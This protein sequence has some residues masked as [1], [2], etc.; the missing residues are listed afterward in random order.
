MR[1]R[2]PGFRLRLWWQPR[3]PPKTPFDP[4]TPEEQ[5]AEALLLRHLSPAQ[6]KTYL[7]D[8]WFEVRG[9]DGSLWTIDSDGGS[10]NVRCI[11]GSGTWVYCSFLPD[12]PRADTLLVQKLCIEATGGRGLPRSEGGSVTDEHLFHTTPQRRRRAIAPDPALL[13]QAALQYRAVSRLKYAE[14]LLRQ[15]IRIEDRRLPADSPRRPHRRTEL[16]LVLL[17]RGRFTAARRIAA[18]AWRLA[19]GRDDLI[20]A[21][22]LVVRIAAGW[23]GR[24]RD[25]GLQLGQLKTLAAGG[26]PRCPA[27]IPATWHVADVIETL[28]RKLPGAQAELVVQLVKVIE[29]RARPTALDIF[30]AWTTAAPVPLDAP[31]PPP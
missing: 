24:K 12:V 18:E 25:V 2:L 3:R 10:R 29:R 7:R 4:L 16:A 30:P 6:Q 14:H 11:N 23:L 1:F 20:S 28:R 17:R 22:L 13:S 8:G 15:A 21:R 31:W 27:G 19:D 5:R 26:T 9:R